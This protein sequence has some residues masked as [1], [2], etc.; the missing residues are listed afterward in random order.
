MIEGRARDQM[1]I[2]R[3]RE[4]IRQQEQEEEER[5]R[6]RDEARR[7]QLREAIENQEL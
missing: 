4:R 5:R 7:L 6:A 3:M 2:D 1:R